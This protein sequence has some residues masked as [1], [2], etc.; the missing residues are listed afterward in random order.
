MHFI[1]FG[2]AGRGERFGC[3][4]GSGLR[5]I[6]GTEPPI[7]HKT[8]IEMPAEGLNSSICHNNNIIMHLLSGIAMTLSTLTIYGRKWRFLTTLCRK[9]I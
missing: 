1:F 5:I 3:F 2:G 9:I 4:G 6:D 7:A 8:K